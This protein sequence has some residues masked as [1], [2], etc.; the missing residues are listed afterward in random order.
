MTRSR[1]RKL[2]EE[3]KA[4][5]AAKAKAK[6]KTATRP[7]I[8]AIVIITSLKHGAQGQIAKVAEYSTDGKRVALITFYNSQFFVSQVEDIRPATLAEK[9]KKRPSLRRIPIPDSMERSILNPR[10]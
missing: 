5:A 4:K 3:A 7:S 9:N 6:P 8:G 2:A 1:T 10:Y